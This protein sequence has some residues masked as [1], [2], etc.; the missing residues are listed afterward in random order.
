M[1]M[2]LVLF[3]AGGLGVFGGLLRHRP[4]LVFVSG[5]MLLFHALP[6]ALFDETSASATLSAYSDTAIAI[7]VIAGPAF[8]LGYWVFARAPSASP[9]A[10]RLDAPP[11]LIHGL[12][13]IILAGLIAISPG[14]PLG[15]AEAGLLRV[16]VE[17][18][19]HSTIYAL[20]CVVAFTT[21]IL[22][23]HAA[24]ERS[25]QPWLSMAIVLL[26]FWM[27]G[28]RTQFAITGIAFCLVLLRHGQLRMR[29]LLVPILVTGLLSLMTLS[30]RL[31][32]QGQTT[33]LAATIS[34]TLSQ[35]SLLEGY[36]LAARFVDEAG[37]QV[38]H[39]WATAMQLLPRAIFP[40]KPL[41]LSRE[42]RF[43]AARDTLGGLTPGL[44]GEAFAAGG[45][46]WV[47]A[48][49]I[50]FGGVLALVD[51]AYRRLCE[52]APVSQALV[53]SL[54]PLLAIFVMRGG[55]DTAIFRLAILLL[56]GGLMGLW[57]ASRQWFLARALLR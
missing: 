47:A 35:L 53:V 39:Y 46:I 16:P 54:L 40:E 50:A 33:D 38:G 8:Y 10:E 22:S 48:I 12:L 9:S 15:F 19:L 1:T 4:G 37:H 44:A 43:M 18:P 42:L 30:F 29:G 41:Q 21:A 49:G 25:G 17:S 20:A 5:G 31:S 6:I 57:N 11:R 13:L 14:G 32:L 55:L 51:N 2:A 56:A 36:A 7:A 45:L 27:L 24:A 3:V 52:L 28:G 34:M 23:A 26:V